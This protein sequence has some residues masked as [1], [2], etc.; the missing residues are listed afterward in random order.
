[1]NTMKQKEENNIYDVT[2]HLV[3]RFGPV[4]SGTWRAAEDRAW[5]EYNA[6]ILQK[7]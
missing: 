1:M 3:E 6:E 7:K 2:R 5:E 4:G